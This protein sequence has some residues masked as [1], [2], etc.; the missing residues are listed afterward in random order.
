VV[1]GLGVDVRGNLAENAKMIGLN[2]T[3]ALNENPKMIGLNPAA[4]LNMSLFKPHNL[5]YVKRCIGLK[6]GMVAN[7][8]PLIS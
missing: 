3:A 2:L 8:S 6:Q 1:A 5:Y 4:A 7:Q